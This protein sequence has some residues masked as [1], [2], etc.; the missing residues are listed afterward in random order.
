MG[1]SY[2]SRYFGPFFQCKSHSC[3]KSIFL[4]TALK[5]VC[6]QNS[7][8]MSHMGP[9]S[10]PP[11][12]MG[13]LSHGSHSMPPSPMPHGSMPPSPMPHSMMS[14]QLP[15]SSPAPASGLMTPHQMIPSPMPTMSP[16]PPAQIPASPMIPSAPPTPHYEQPIPSPA[17]SSA[18]PTPHPI[19]S[20]E[21]NLESFQN[22]P[23]P[24]QPIHQENLNESINYEPEPKRLRTESA[25]M[26]LR[27]VEAGKGTAAC[28]KYTQVFTHTKILRN[29]IIF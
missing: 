26:E 2:W 10:I 1:E 14:H 16:H 23:T 7:H 4:S 9:G 8:Q 18:P 15:V 28:I 29:K 22:P 3:E 5:S 19:E 27:D 21:E 13:G 11:S 20:P 24:I 12:P 17:Q 6:I 25:E